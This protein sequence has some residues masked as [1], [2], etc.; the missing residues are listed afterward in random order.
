[1]TS[2]E[3]ILAAEIAQAEVEG[4]RAARSFVT[5]DPYASAWALHPEPVRAPAPAWASALG[6]PFPCSER[7][8]RTAFKRRA[9]ATHPDRTGASAEPFLEA[10]VALEAGLRELGACAARAR[11]TSVERYRW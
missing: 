9:F 4:A 3:E 1:M 5:P 2:F 7:E 8:L 11:R 10:Q 6:T